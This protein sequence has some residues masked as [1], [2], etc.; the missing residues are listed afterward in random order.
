ML[1]M[2]QSFDDRSDQVRSMKKA[3]HDKDITNLIGIIYAE[4]NT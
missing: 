1:K 4:K 2:K 3:K